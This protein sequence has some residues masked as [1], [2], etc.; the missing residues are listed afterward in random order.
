MKNEKGTEGTL[1]IKLEHVRKVYP[2][3][4]PLSDVNAE[5]RGGRL[6]YRVLRHGKEHAAP[7][8][9]PSGAAERGQNLF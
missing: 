9:Q 5:I 6:H 7:L 2:N 1:M 4:V 3:A 8:H